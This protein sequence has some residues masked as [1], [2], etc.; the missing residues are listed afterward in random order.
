[1]KKLIVI[2]V[3]ISAVN[4]SFARELEKQ[5]RDVI[6]VFIDCVR[7]DDVSRLS[8]LMFYPLKRQYP[9]PAINNEIEFLSRYQEIFDDSLKEIIVSSDIENDWSNVG[10]RGMM[11]HNGLLWLSYDGTFFSITY[12]SDF[13]RNRRAELIESDKKSIHQSLRVF[14]NPIL[15]IETEKFRVRIDEM[16]NG[17]YRYA[18]WGMK[19]KM[20]EKPD[21]VLNDGEFAAEGTGGALKYKFVN[22]NYRY[23]V[24]VGRILTPD[25]PP[26][27][28]TVY[29]G[30]DEIVNQPALELWN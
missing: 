11:F 19:T 9:L 30:E 22:G 26:A 3:L 18:S 4:L 17:K 29:K 28:L 16:K 10:W 23:V 13:E 14:D 21:L 1:M 25:S 2:L 7:Y 20:S 15:I 12:K 5:Y 6:E 27:S 8:T 24:S